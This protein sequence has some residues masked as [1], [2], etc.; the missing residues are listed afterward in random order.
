MIKKPFIDLRAIKQ[1]RF[2]VAQLRALLFVLGLSILLIPVAIKSENS[3]KVHHK[4][5]EIQLTPNE[6]AWLKTHPEVRVAVKHGWMP[7]EFK[8]ESNQ[9]RGISVDYLQA[10]SSIFDIRFVLSD[11]SEN[12]NTSA[13]DVISGVVSTNVKYPQFKRQPYPFLTFPFAIYVNKKSNDRLEITSMADL[14]NKRVAVFKNGPVA[15]EIA[16]NYPQIKLLYVDIADEAIEELRLQRVDAYIGNEI[17]IDYHIVVHRLKFVEKVAMTPFS[18]DV[19]MAVRDDLP[20]LASILNK[21]LQA[22][23][24]NNQEILE[25]WQISDNQYNRWLVPVAIIAS[26]FLILGLMRIFKLKQTIR[27]QNFEAQKTI[28]H[29]ANYDYLTDLPNRHLLDSRLRQAM[30]KADESLSPVGILFID[31]DN[32]KHVNDTAGHSIGDKLIKEAANRITRCVRAY[33]TTA[34]FGGDEFMVVMS[35]FDNEEAL[36]K[37][38]KK[39]LAV[40][41]QPFQIDNELFYISASIGLTIYPNDTSDPEALF[42]YADQAMYEAK[43]LGRNRFQFFQA[44]MQLDTTTRLALMNDLR[45]AIAQQ[46]F[47]LYYQPIINLDTQEILK[48]EALIRWN[49]PLK[50]RINPSEF[51]ALAEETGLIEEIGAWVFNQVLH[52]IKHVHAQYSPDFQVSVNVSPK[53]FIRPERLLAWKTAIVNAGLA[54]RH[55]CIEIT[56]GLLLQ[57]SLSVVNTI[58]ALRD[59]G[60]QFSIDDFGTGYSALAYLNKFDIEYV[61]IDRSFTH[62]LQAN[63]QDAIL[64]EAITSMAHKLGMTVVAEGIETEAQARMLTGFECDYGQGYLISKPKSFADFMQFLSEHQ[65]NNH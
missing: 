53:Q 8:L 3:V 1:Y 61:K 18:S 40:L 25:N 47:E 10:L 23:G 43:K 48:A 28:W 49:H 27:R 5:G 37:T 59:F 35:D 19:S 15:R 52:D 65:K 22:I 31:L 55:I 32:F 17:I 51:I 62:N 29:Q 63:N 34:R 30:D 13:V 14:N 45:E 64:C 42:S 36:E 46:Q 56:E 12:M 33:D 4:Y 50:G 2:S 7:I 41:Q 21:G 44:S 58:S 57:P 54:G 11:Y 60:I 38:S 6:V 16:A 9:H 20:E 24:R 39:I 26:L